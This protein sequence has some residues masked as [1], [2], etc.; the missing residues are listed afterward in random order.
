M[1][2]LFEFAKNKKKIEMEL[3]FATP[4][5]IQHLFY[6]VLDKDN[7]NKSHWQTE[8]Y[9]FLNSIELI[10]GKNKLPDKQFIYTNS[11]GEVQDTVQNIKWIENTADSYCDIENIETAKSTYKIMEELDFICSNYFDWLAEKLSTVGSVKRKEVVTEIDEL[12]DYVE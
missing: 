8:I 5:I 7:I 6:L 12:L 10:K 3:C 2:T 9:A 11:Y 1:V 4:K